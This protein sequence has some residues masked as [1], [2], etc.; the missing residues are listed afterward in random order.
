MWGGGEDREKSGWGRGKDREDGEEEMMGRAKDGEE[1]NKRPSSCY[2]VANTLLIDAYFSFHQLFSHLA[3]MVDH[4][5]H[6]M[7]T[8]AHWM[9]PGNDHTHS[10]TVKTNGL[11]RQLSPELSMDLQCSGSSAASCVARPQ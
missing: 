8:L 3:K 1:G 5:Q 2:S 10:Y 6:S 9:Q 7:G 4:L 11:N